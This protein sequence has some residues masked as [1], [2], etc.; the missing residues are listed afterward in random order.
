[1]YIYYK[2]LIIFS[3]ALLLCQVRTLATLVIE[4]IANREYK[5]IDDDYY[6]GEYICYSTI[7][8][9]YVYKKGIKNYEKNYLHIKT[10]VT[11]NLSFKIQSP[12]WIKRT[13]NLDSVVW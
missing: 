7:K 11:I 1:M 13:R 10:T 8:V 5:Y 3:Q 4:R 12:E 9:Q 6:M 2:S